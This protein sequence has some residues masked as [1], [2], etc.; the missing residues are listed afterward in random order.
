MTEKSPEKKRT[1]YIPKNS[2][3]M[4]EQMLDRKKFAYAWVAI[5]KYDHSVD[6]YEARGWVKFKTPDGKVVRL[7]EHYLAQMPIDQFEARQK[8]KDEQRDEQTRLFFDTQAAEEE[9][10]SHDFRKKGGKVKFSFTQD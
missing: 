2:F 3:D 8:Y 4:P 10:L 1:T 7:E 5:K 9:R 6:E